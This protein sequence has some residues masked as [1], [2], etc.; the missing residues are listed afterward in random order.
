MSGINFTPNLAFDKALK[1]YIEH[2]KSVGI[3]PWEN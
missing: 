1:R 3:L 2:C